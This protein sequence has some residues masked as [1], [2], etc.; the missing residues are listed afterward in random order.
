MPSSRSPGA[1]RSIAPGDR[2]IFIEAT[3]D[4][5]GTPIN[6]PGGDSLSVTLTKVRGQEDP[7]AGRRP[8]YIAWDPVEVWNRT[9]GAALHGTRSG[10]PV[11]SNG[12]DMEHSAFAD[13]MYN[14]LS[15]TS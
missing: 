12:T 9:G 8:D 11:S 5:F 3:S 7:W 14:K 4:P 6:V 2:V 10:R 13:Q 15:I 1:S